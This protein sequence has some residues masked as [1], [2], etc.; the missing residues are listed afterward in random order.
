MNFSAA[1]TDNPGLA[2]PRRL[3]EMVHKA[4]WERINRG[5]YPRNTRLPSERELAIEFDVS[6]PVIRAALAR[7]REAGLVT[8]VKGSGTLV[9]HEPEPRIEATPP[10]TT[11]RDLQRCF[12]F[13]VLIEG[14]AAY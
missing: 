3:T 12:E 4:L 5:L 8:S 13:R 10:G 1:G 6:R 2:P 11:I 9:L 7:L 14:E